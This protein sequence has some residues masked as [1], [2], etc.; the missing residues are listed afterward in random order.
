[1]RNGLKNL[2]N[3]DSL[4]NKGVRRMKQKDLTVQIV[5]KLHRLGADLTG[6]ASF[7]TMLTYGEQ[8]SHVKKILPKAKSVL[9]FGLRMID[10]TI[11]PSKKNIRLAQF[12]TKCLYEELDRISFGIS[13][14]L[15]DLGYRAISYS[16][17][18]P[19]EMRKET[20][21]M[22]GDIS[23][24]HTAFEAGLGTFGKSRLLLTERFGPRVRF[25]S[26]VTDAPLKPGKRLKKDFCKNCDLCIKACP[27][28]AIGNDGN[29]D[30]LKC[31]KEILK[32]GLPGVYQFIKGWI[33]TSE[34]ARREMLKSPTFWE[35]WQNLTSGIFYY[36]FECLNACPVGK[37]RRKDND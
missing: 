37:R 18:L 19:V 7:E 4:K 1:L 6:V 35:I 30:V 15:D 33:E 8:W 27:S 2:R 14:Y 20:M 13:R 24:R 16:P 9:V 29:V 17:Y 36:C 10:S 34:D 12:S 11:A 21:G 3:P 23:H 26:I 32:L 31:S 5:K 28:S 25:L 22:I